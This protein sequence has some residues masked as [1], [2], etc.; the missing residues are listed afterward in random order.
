M[1]LDEKYIDSLAPDAASISAGKGLVNISKWANIGFNE[2]ALWG[3]CQGSGSKPYKTQ[4]DIRENAFKC[5]CPSRKFPCKHGLG[6]MY[7]FTKYKQNFSDTP[8]NWVQEWLSSRDEKKQKQEEKKDK[9]KDISPEQ[10]AKTEGKR[11]DSINKGLDDLEIWLNDFIR[12][13]FDSIKMESYSFFNNIASRMVDYKASGLSRRINE[14]SSISAVNSNNDL[15]L[16]KISKIHLILKAFRNIEKLPN[17]IQEDL[18]TELGI[19]KNQDE[20]LNLESINDKW[21]VLGNLIEEED[22]IKTKKIFLFGLKTKKIALVLDFS[23][24]KKPFSFLELTPERFF[25]GDLIYYPSNLEL[26]AIFKNK[27]LSSTE[28][29][30]ISDNNIESVY[31]LYSDSLAKNPFIEKIPTF[32]SDV[33]VYCKDENSFII[34]DENKNF[35]PISKKFKNNWELLLKVK[36]NK[37]NIFGEFDGENFLPVTIFNQDYFYSF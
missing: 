31:N 3:E 21:L 4:I 14:L 9:V 2:I 15:I 11:F 13:G 17:L 16:K 29:L 37:I 25:E 22:K 8:P 27:E 30:N 35:L 5:S 20:I 26:R 18:K 1:E 10:K 32:I 28:V 34:F 6:L 12:R 7:L 23:V 36:N 19:T 33:N 24:S